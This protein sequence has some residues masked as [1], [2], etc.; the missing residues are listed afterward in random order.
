[1]GG[2]SAVPGALALLARLTRVADPHA[3]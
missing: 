2:L 3:R 1:M